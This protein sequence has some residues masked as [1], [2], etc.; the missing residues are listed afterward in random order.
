MGGA[1]L[2]GRVPALSNTP[3]KSSLLSAFPATKTIE[4]P[5]VKSSVGHPAKQQRLPFALLCIQAFERTSSEVTECQ[6][7]RKAGCC[8]W[9]CCAPC[10]WVA[11]A[12]GS[13]SWGAVLLQPE[14][15]F[16]PLIHHKSKK[17]GSPKACH[18]KKVSITPQNR[19][20]EMRFLAKL[21]PLNTCCLSQFARVPVR[22]W[23]RQAGS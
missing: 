10:T 16:G 6:K 22:V 19:T 17:T 7:Q 2:D 23:R 1:W 3:P 21:N 15:V 5:W 13:Q 14:R 4:A 18:S 11:Q 12:S 8:G 9:E 20:R